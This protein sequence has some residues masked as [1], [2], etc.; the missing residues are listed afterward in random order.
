MISDQDRYEL[1]RLSAKYKKQQEKM[2]KTSDKIDN[3]VE[4]YYL[5]DE[6]DKKD[7]ERALKDITELKDILVDGYSKFE[8][9]H[10]IKAYN[11]LLNK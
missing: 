5:K 4:R 10:R 1:N 11:E 2:Y 7:I 9:R 3:I 6:Y 8:I